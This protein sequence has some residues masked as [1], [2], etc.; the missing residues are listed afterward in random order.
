MTAH[1]QGDG[2]GNGPG[3]GMGSRP[4]GPGFDAPPQG[5]GHGGVPSFRPP[6]HPLGTSTD[7]GTLPSPDPDRFRAPRS[8]LPLVVTAA[9]L[10]G[11]IGV[12][13]IGAW[14]ANR[15]VE[16]PPQNSPSATPPAGPTDAP[17]DAPTDD[18]G[19]IPFVSSEGSG[20]LRLVSHDWT[21]N[22][23]RPPSAG[24]YLVLEVELESTEG[25]IS[26]APE[27][28]QLFDQDA[29]LV[30][31]TPDGAP[32]PV[33]TTGTL[34]PGETITGHVAFDVSRSEVTLLLTNAYSDSVTA[35]RIPG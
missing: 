10:V 6:T 14:Q 13:L 20:V 32:A 19:S 17:T 11:L 26:F 29:R 33:M 12:I 24:Q 16:A 1:G 4:Q 7:P 28:F 31:A 3:P 23:R 21:E 35:L 8:R 15:P 22:G 25:E 30:N 18:A 9:V 5:Y 27:Y 34:G 2:P